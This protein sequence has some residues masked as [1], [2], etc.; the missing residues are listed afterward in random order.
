METIPVAMSALSASC[1]QVSKPLLRLS[2]QLLRLPA[3][4]PMAPMC[5][6]TPVVMAVMVPAE[7]G[8]CESV[9]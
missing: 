8:V 1:S 9:L 7:S 4:T 6:F 2:V 3:L 5:D